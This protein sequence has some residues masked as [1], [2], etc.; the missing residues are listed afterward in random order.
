MNVSEA[1]HR[2]GMDVGM[3][4]LADMTGM[5]YDLLR[6]KLS[7]N[8]PRNH[9]H[10]KESV[11]L[12]SASGRADI[13]HAMAE[14]LGY[15][16]MPLPEITSTSLPRAITRACA[17]FG[18]YMRKVDDVF[19]DGEVTPNEVKA[20]EKEL[21]EMIAAATRLQAVLV[22]TGKKQPETIL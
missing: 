15:V 12:Q 19:D 8:N 17:E 3:K 7:L 13:L 20:L 5:D 10:L 9:L 18:D 22:G 2:I 6:A 4:R 1:A 21:T 14:E 16:A 11:L